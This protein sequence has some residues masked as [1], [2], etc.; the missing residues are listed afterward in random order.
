MN[1]TNTTGLKVITCAAAALAL[2]VASTWSFVDATSKVRVLPTTVQAL[3]DHS[4]TGLAQVTTAA[5]VD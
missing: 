1:A 5:L 3:L 4:M 2:T